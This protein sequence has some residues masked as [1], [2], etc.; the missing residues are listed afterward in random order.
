MGILVEF[1]NPEPAASPNRRIAPQSVNMKKPTIRIPAR[2]L[3]EIR[4]DLERS[5]EFAYERIGFIHSRF[6]HSGEQS[7]VIATG[8][9][10]V[11]ENHYIDDPTV[12]VRIGS[13]AI[14]AA[15]QR[16]LHEQ[17]GLFHVHAHG[18]NH[19]PTMS[20]LDAREI[21]PI[22]RSLK[23]AAPTQPFG[24]AL[25]SNDNISA[26]VLRDCGDLVEVSRIVVIG[27]SLQ[28]FQS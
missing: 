4:S 24:I 9:S 20:S 12:P 26:F 22:V 11:A 3:Q 25:L 1:A 17:I 19:K 8:Y 15:M 6:A 28:I 14:Q 2:L 13:A 18:G 5:H 21:P 16:V 7:I 27:S 23:N 10:P